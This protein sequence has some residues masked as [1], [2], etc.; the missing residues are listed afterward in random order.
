MTRRQSL[1]ARLEIGIALN[2]AVVPQDTVHAEAI[3]PRRLAAADR[4]T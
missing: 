4:S 1:F 2:P 3:E